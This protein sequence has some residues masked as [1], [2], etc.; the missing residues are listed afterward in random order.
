MI[1]K[2]LWWLPIVSFVINELIKVEKMTTWSISFCW[3]SSIATLIYVYDL[4]LDGNIWIIIRSFGTT[5]FMSCFFLVKAS[6]L[7]NTAVTFSKELKIS[8]CLLRFISFCKEIL[9]ILRREAILDGIHSSKW[10]Y[11]TLKTYHPL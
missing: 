4:Y 1:E 9:T 6:R 10:T 2:V 11:P 8:A 5:S 3:H 7:E